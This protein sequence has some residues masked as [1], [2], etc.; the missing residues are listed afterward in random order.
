VTLPPQAGGRGGEELQPVA[1]T[2]TS[3]P[4]RTRPGPLALVGSG[5]FTAPMLATDARLLDL[6]EAAGRPRSV[7]VVPTAAGTEG[8]GVV[9]RWLD[10]AQAHYATLGAEVVEVDVRD[11]AGAEDPAHAAAVRGVGLVYLSG[12]RPDHLHRSLDGSPL[13]ASVLDAW[14]GGAALAG[15]SAGAMVLAAGWP[16]FLRASG[17]WG[18]GLGVVPRTGVVPHFDRFAGRLPRYPQRVARGTPDGWGVL[19]VDEDTALVH[20]EGRWEVEG[21]AGA[22]WLTGSGTVPVGQG[23]TPPTP[24]RP[25]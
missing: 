22:W 12:G 25:T 8:E 9:R 13:L 3:E 7:A 21:L 18:A 24:A 10:L 17:S 19:G 15:C 4:T 11:R 20:A 5:E 6:A 1:V 14:G 16:P 23:P 2:G